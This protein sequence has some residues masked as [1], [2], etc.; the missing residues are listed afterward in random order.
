M[1]LSLQ[2][3]GAST[4]YDHGAAM[5]LSRRKEMTLLSCLVV[6][7][8]RHHRETLAA[9]DRWLHEAAM[10]EPEHPVLPSL[11]E[12]LDVLRNSSNPNRRFGNP[13]L[14]EE[15]DARK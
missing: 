8:S 9:A 2:L 6:T 11:T 7:R 4:L 15:T 14:P 5:P 1:T 12:Q 13:K 3:F 10:L